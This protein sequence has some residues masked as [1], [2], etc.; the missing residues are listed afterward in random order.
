MKQFGVKYGRKQ[1]TDDA[2][3]ENM[4]LIEE[5]K[6]DSFDSFQQEMETAEI[7]EVTYLESYISYFS[8]NMYILIDN[9]GSTRMK[10]HY[11]YVCR[12]DG[13]GGD[14]LNLTSLRVPSYPPINLDSFRRKKIIARCSFSVPIASHAAF[15]TLQRNE[16]K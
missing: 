7:K 4:L 6:H 13:V 9:F 11:P 3:G 8:T 15:F 10:T 16:E 5:S 1:K 12:I 14:A 2:K